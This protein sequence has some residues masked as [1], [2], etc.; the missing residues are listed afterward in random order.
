[1]LAYIVRRLLYVIPIVFGVAVVVFTL[2]NLVGGDPTYQMV[3]KHANPEVI[4]E[5]RAELGLDRPRW[6]QFFDYLKQIVTFDYGRSYASKQPISE[7]ILAGLGPS[8]SL[9]VPAFFVTLIIALSIGLVVAYFRGKWVDRVT[10]IFCVLGM[11]IPALAVILFGQY[12]LA[13]QMGWFP[14]SGYTGGFPGFI[15]YILLPMLIW[16]VVG[17]GMDVRFFRTAILDETQQDYVRTARAKGLSEPKIYFKHVLKNSMIPILTYV[18]IQI[19][20]LVLG[21]L[22]L[23]SFFGIPGLGSIT[24]DAVNNSDFPVLK[25][26]AT[27]ISMLFILGNLLTDILYK[28]VDPRVDLK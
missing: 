11:S 25:A 12:V 14:I 24:L 1:M 27:I 8:L 10:V 22:L 20:F 16:V 13:Y 26:M 2:F 23:E 19:P 3:G 17:L 4:A 7:M 28:V 15:S 6:V 18:V 9:S 21:A 5:L